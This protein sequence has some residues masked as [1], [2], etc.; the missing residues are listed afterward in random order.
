M[1]KCA[2]CGR[3]ITNEYYWNGEIYGKECWKE[4]ALPEIEKL[5]EQKLDEWS[6]KASC[7]IEVLKQKDMSKITNDFKIRFI[8]SI[9][10]QYQES[11]KLSKKQYNLAHDFLNKKDR[12]KLY[13]MEFELGLMDEYTFYYLMHLV[14]PAKLIKEYEVKLKEYDL[15]PY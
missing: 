15:W 11:H 1:S 8:K 4:I 2:K 10:E 5:R 7:L 12:V 3:K 13:H 14:A 6:L 9:I